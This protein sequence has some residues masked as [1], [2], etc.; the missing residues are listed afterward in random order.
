MKV[1]LDAKLF[2]K[3]EQLRMKRYYAEHTEEFQDFESVTDFIHWFSQE[4]RIMNYKCH[5]CDTSILDIRK[6]YL[7]NKIPTVE[8]MHFNFCLQSINKS[9]KISMYNGLLI[10]FFC[11]QEHHHTYDYGTYKNIVGPQRRIYW[12]N[13]LRSLHP[14]K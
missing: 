10:C 8:G 5:Y 11:R 1:T 7:H 9:K 3:Q 2:K 14:L 13:L 12:K 4:M 6:L